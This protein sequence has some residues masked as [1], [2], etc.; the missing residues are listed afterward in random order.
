MS[1]QLANLMIGQ[2]PTL[3]YTSELRKGRHKQWTWDLLATTNSWNNIHFSTLKHSLLQSITY[4]TSTSHRQPHYNYHFVY[5]SCL[6]QCL[7]ISLYSIAKA[8]FH[9]CCAS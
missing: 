9:S 7:E 2:M 4:C 1:G 6:S 8:L 5:H 3:G